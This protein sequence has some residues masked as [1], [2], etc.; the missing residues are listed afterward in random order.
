MLLK[1]ACAAGEVSADSLCDIARVSDTII[2]PSE[3][4]YKDLDY[5][6]DWYAYPAYKAYGMGV[7]TGMNETTFGAYELVSRAQ[8]TTML[9]R[10]CYPD[11]R[12]TD[13]YY[14]L[15][16]DVK[17]DDW[18]KK[19]VMW[20]TVCNIATGYQ[21]GVFGAADPITREQMAAMLYRYATYKKYDT[22]TIADLNDFSDAAA[23]S[24]F[25]ETAMQ[26]C[27]ANGIILGK[28][29][30]LKPQD[31]TTRAECAAMI[32]RFAEKYSFGR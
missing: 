7:M 2:E 1:D 9:Q 23:V 5:E 29:G 3:L 31:Y 8:F 26:W 17:E 10:L 4:L 27:V 6:N 21:R 11:T 28:D 14:P 15:Y 30:A 20:A 32:T 16:E 12:W 22:T 13:Y 25:A 18:Y 19:G 24:K